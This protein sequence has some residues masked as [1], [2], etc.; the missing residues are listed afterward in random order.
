MAYERLVIGEWYH[1]SSNHLPYHLFNGVGFAQFFYN[2]Y[3]TNIQ[4]GYLALRNTMFVATGGSSVLLAIWYGSNRKK[5]DHRIFLM[6][7]FKIYMTLFLTFIVVPYVY[8]MI[9]GNFVTI[10][11]FAEQARYSEKK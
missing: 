2:T 4:A 7:S 1:L 9:V 5:M 11:I 8:L 3:Q 10:A 6:A